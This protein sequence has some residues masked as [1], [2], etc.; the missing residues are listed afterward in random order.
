[1][2]LLL[3]CGKQGVVLF[4]DIPESGWEQQNWMRF[5]YTHRLP[6]KEVALNWVL[7]HDD[8]YPFANIHLITEWRNPKGKVKS[9]TLSYLLA[10]SNGRW[11]G[12]GFYVVEH[13]LP[14]KKRYVLEE[15]GNYIF[16]V[17]PAV[18]DTDK[19]VAEKKLL[20]IRQIG[21]S[22]NPLSND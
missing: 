7:R 17:R 3:G 4:A 2:L 14:F 5:Q 15:P 11:L 6:Q 16:R 22:L 20:G 13:H 19:L 21:I 10:E 1:M 8:D 18:R 9:D 12:K